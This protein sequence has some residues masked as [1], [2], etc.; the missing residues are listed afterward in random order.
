MIIIK[1]KN[2][3]TNKTAKVYHYK[4]EKEMLKKCNF[5]CSYSKYDVEK[6]YSESFVI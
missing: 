5:G 2:R 4:N 3:K 6:Y 1:I